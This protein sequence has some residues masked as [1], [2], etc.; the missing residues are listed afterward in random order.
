MK[1]FIS[2][3]M[4]LLVLAC[5]LTAAWAEEEIASET[6]TEVVVTEEDNEAEETS[7]IEVGEDELGYTEDESA[8]DPTE[9][10]QQIEDTLPQR[11]PDTW[12]EAIHSVATSQLGY[13]PYVSD[14]AVYNRYI[15]W[16][17][18]DCSF[19]AAFVSFCVY[20]AGIPSVELKTYDTVPL[21]LEAME[22]EK[23]PLL[24]EGY[25]PVVG[26]LIFLDLE[27]EDNPQAMDE[28]GEPLFDEDDEPVLIPTADHIGLVSRYSEELELL[29]IVGTDHVEEII[30]GPEQIIGFIQLPEKPEE[31]E[32]EE[33]AQD[34]ESASEET[35]PILD[36]ESLPYTTD[37]HLLAPDGY[38][39]ITVPGSSVKL[40]QTCLLNSEPLYWNE[41][42]ECFYTMVPSGAEL[43]FQVVEGER[44]SLSYSPDINE[45]G[46]VNIADANAVYQMIQNGGSYYTVEQISVEAR[47]ALDYRNITDFNAVISLIN[48]NGIPQAAGHG[49]MPAGLAFICRFARK[50][51]GQ[52]NE[53]AVLHRKTAEHAAD[54]LTEVF[55]RSIMTRQLKGVL[56]GSG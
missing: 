12:H 51:E 11:L 19:D 35:P 26:D 4:A 52:I 25:E 53:F 28:D 36:G 33:P 54:F 46:V 9:T 15:W 48:G 6:V 32:E 34:E 7:A 21:W 41:E 43:L 5:T 27:T 31:P 10:I 18:R 40:E 2:L 3:L 24:L 13:T 1:E 16:S 20:Y 49:C 37:Y 22:K 17:G 44:T 56:E 39:Y 29:V 38:M 47:L 55:L 50:T 42:S 23:S 45:D 14:T 8:Y 30:I